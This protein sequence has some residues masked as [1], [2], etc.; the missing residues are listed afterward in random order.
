M[1]NKELIVFL[2]EG[3]EEIEAITS[4]DILRRAGVDVT[5]VSLDNTKVHGSH[6]VD[7]IADE[8]LDNIVTEEYDG[9]VLPGGMPG[10]AN[11]RDDKRVIKILEKMYQKDK[12]IAAI[13]AAPLA[14]IEAGVVKDGHFTIH[15]GME[16]KIELNSTGDRITVDNN[17]IT[18]KGPGVAIEFGF[19]IVEKLIGTDKVKELNEGIYAKL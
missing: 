11:L 1:R 12:L 4:I 19:N 18:A 13:C 14:L 6:E 10:S 5:T 9:V 3:L 15:H 16:D 2:A 7:I 8:K 17:I